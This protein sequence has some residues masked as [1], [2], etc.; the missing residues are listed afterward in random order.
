[1]EKVILDIATVAPSALLTILTIAGL[2]CAKFL[3]SMDK[4]I[5]SIKAYALELHN[6]H[7][8]KIT[9]LEIKQLE[10]DEAV[11]THTLKI[12]KH[13]EDIAQLK[14]KVYKR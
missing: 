3:W 8:K 14:V 12:D 1:M 11:K 7:E 5:S 4:N 2:F 13:G 9:V 10:V 6:L